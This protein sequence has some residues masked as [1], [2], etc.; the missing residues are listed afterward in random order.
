MC[1]K[2]CGF[3]LNRLV[4]YKKVAVIYIRIAIY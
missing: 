3:G 2:I 1:F 4:A